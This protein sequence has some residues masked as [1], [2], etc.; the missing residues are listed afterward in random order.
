MITQDRA[1][2]GLALAV[3]LVVGLSPRSAHA[4]AAAEKPVLAVIGFESAFDEGKAGTFVANSLLKKLGRTFHFQTIEPSSVAD[5]AAAAGFTFAFDAAPADI[6]K[7]AADALGARIVVW[8][9]VEKQGEGYVIHVRV[10]D[11][12][13]PGDQP[14]IVLKEATEDRRPLALACDRLAEALTPRDVQIR[15][16]APAAIPEENRPNLLRNGDFEKGDRS[17]EGWERMDNLSQIW[18]DKGRPG[19]C[20][21]QDTDVLEKEVLDWRKQI[22]A[23]ADPMKPPTKSVTKGEKYDTIAATYGVHYRSD[24]LP[25]EPGVTYRVSLDVKGKSILGKIPFFPKCFIKGY[26][27]FTPGEFGAQD[28]EVCNAYV[29]CRTGTGG[30]EWEHFS[31]TVTPN[32]HLCIYDFE[33]VDP[34]AGKAAADG[35]RRTC[36]KSKYAVLDYAAQQEALAKAGFAPGFDMALPEILRFTTQSLHAVVAVWGKVE[37]VDAGRALKVRVC[38]LR[39]KSS[40]PI[41][42]AEFP[43][44]TEAEARAAHDGFVAKLRD[45]VRVAEYV[46]IVPYVYWPPGPFYWDNIRVTVEDRL[47]RTTADDSPDEPVPPRPPK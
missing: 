40:I 21:F 12:S 18:S 31:L 9:K 4:G 14:Q 17:P 20:L 43:Y 26:A 2:C 28:R 22:A 29:A 32:P 3:C 19:K 42:D 5:A 10:W 27:P 30:R 46:R 41:L 7:F 25:V 11:L 13:K 6:R 1:I 15:R 35:L 36:G 44:T 34:A 38:S 47:P 16:T 39:S 24:P 33:S 23:G 45:V 37:K 8:G